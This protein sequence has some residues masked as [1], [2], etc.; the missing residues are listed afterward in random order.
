M[1][2]IFI[3]VTQLMRWE[4][5]LTGV[6]RVQHE[7]ISR[8]INNENSIFVTWH[9]H[10]F[11]EIKREDIFKTEDLF[12]DKHITSDLLNV[13]NAVR[14]ALKAKRVLGRS[15]HVRYLNRKL[16][17]MLSAKS[18]KDASIV[19]PAPGDALFII[20]GIWSDE[21]YIQK[22]ITF[23][24]GGVRIV[25][26]C[27][28]ILPLVTPQFSGHSTDWLDNYVKKIYPICTLVLSI[29]KHT[30]QD[31]AAWLRMQKLEVP[32]LEMFRLGENFELLEPL[33]PNEDDI[34]RNSFILSVG[35][36]EV[37]KN[38]T[39]LYYTYKQ[40][41]LKQ[42]ELPKIVL[43][44]RKGWKTENIYDLMTTDPDVKDK[45]IFLHNASDEELVWLYKNC[46]F[47]VYP[48]F[49][50]G[51]GLPIAESMYHGVPCLAS[52]TSSMPE[53]A[54]NLISYF[55]PTSPDKLLEQI[56]TLLEPS[57]LKEARLKV[58]EYKITTW[59]ESYQQVKKYIMEI[60]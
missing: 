27:Y 57:N 11:C 36:I 58:K 49:Y 44:G 53:I 17:T 24:G 7:L 13:K 8:F 37:R 39:L 26:I 41:A 3:D 50:E 21:N 5:R 28:D 15:K 34:R 56:L 1:K 52:N 25:Q 6:P 2:K 14:L 54:G 38:H 23:N 43:V 33:K 46:L 51:W 55:D 20:E 31:V 10:D 32:K 48:S 42:I 22:I 9:G 12:N 47:T 35:T 45:I 29:S 30:M 59:D 60:L 4:G 19:V 18:A 40:A 16:E